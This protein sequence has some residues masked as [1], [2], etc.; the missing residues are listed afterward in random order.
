[1]YAAASQH[2]LHESSVIDEYEMS[3][4]RALQSTSGMRSWPFFN[5][6]PALIKVSEISRNTNIKDFMENLMER[7]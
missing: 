1:M 3:P 4:V 7:M 2:I 5:R 6:V